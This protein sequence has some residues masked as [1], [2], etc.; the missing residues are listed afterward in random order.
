MSTV[1]AVL[2]PGTSDDETSLRRWTRGEFD[3]ML[4]LDIFPVNEAVE[5]SDGQVY[6]YGAENPRPWTQYEYHRLLDAGVLGWDERVELLEGD[7]VEKMTNNPPH[8][9]CV[10]KT[11]DALRRVFKDG[12]FVREQGPLG[13]SVS[14][15]PGPDAMVVPGVR[16]DYADHHPAP[17]DAI[18]VVEVSDSSLRTDQGRKMRLYAATGVS[19]YWIVNLRERTLEVYRGPTANGYGTKQVYSEAEA[20]TPLAA[21]EASIRVADL[22]P[23][24]QSQTAP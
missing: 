12:Y 19:E 17:V 21:P 6:L 7:I 3:R 24:T 18:L 1:S 8:V 5:L 20:V 13:A 15:E 9:T 22:L 11:V 10:G 14:S 23:R 16:D 4:D 2:A